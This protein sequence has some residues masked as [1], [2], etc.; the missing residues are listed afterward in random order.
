MEEEQIST[1]ASP[2]IQ[3]QGELSRQQL[4]KDFFYQQI[5]QHYKMSLRKSV[6]TNFKRLY[7]GK[8]QIMASFRPKSNR[9]LYLQ[10]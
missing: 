5:S 2:R 6:I 7:E 9:R 4:T 3:I 10:T 1:L 8:K